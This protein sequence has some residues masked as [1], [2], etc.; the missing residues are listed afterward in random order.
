MMQ[1][2]SLPSLKEQFVYERGCWKSE[3]ENGMH[4]CPYNVEKLEIQCFG[5]GRGE[6]LG[7]H[8]KVAKKINMKERWENECSKKYT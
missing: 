1:I 4:C 2:V 3:K 5:G 6:H 8:C 7:L